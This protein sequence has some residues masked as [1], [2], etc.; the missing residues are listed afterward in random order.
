MKILFQGGW[1]EGRDPP[2]TKEIVAAYCHALAKRLANSNHQLI[3]TSNRYYDKLIAEDIHLLSAKANRDS[4]ESLI[5]LLPD[6]YNDIPS[7]GKV[8][9]FETQRWWF[10]ERTFFVKKAD[11][12][13]A[14][15]GGKGTSDS[16]QKAFLAGKPVF[17]A[18]SIPCASAET[19]KKRPTNYNY[20]K[21]NDTEFTEDLNISPDKFIDEMFRIIDLL[22]NNRFPRR[23]FII[24]GR[25]YHSRDTLVSILKKL[26]FEPIVLQREP[27][28][29]LSVIEK[30]ER[31]TIDIGFSFIIYTPDDLGGLSGE[32]QRPRARQNVI[33]E[34]GFLISKLGR[35]RTCALVKEEIEIPSDLKG[36]IYEKFDDLEDEAVKI[37]RILKQAGYEVD[38]NSLV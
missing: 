3:L 33:F 26:H 11:A 15:G 17:V 32:T 22:E 8:F 7:E 25:D 29:S 1:R 12:L 38:A 20:V 2:I 23:V 30:L 27:S 14:I 37:L 18:G 9:R 24:H 34:H 19:W 4:K 5:Y 13:I 16:I 35:E 21:S 28:K 10:E 31:D 36:V 6:R